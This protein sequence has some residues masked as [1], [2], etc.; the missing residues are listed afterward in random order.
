MSEIR[1][2]PA[3]APTDRIASSPSPN[4]LPLGS[5][6]GI[7]GGGQLGR[8]LA[9]AAA[10]LGYTCHVYT[11]DAACPAAHVTPHVTQGAWDDE[12]ALKHF[13]QNIDVATLEFENIPATVCRI[14]DPYVPLFPDQ[15]TLQIAQDRRAEKSFFETFTR[16]TPWRV[17]TSKTGLKA[18]LRTLGTPAI[19]KT[20]C[21]GYDGK[22]QVVIKAPEQAEAAWS[23]LSPHPVILEQWVPF[24]GE[25][26][27]LI[28]RRADGR[29]AAWEPG[30]NIHRNGVLDCT[31]LP[32]PCD[33]DILR[34]AQDI[35]HEAAQ[36]LNLIGL[37]SVEFFVLEDHSLLVNEMAPRPHNSGHWTLD[38]SVTD[39]F[40]QTIRAICGLPLGDTQ[41]RCS[42]TMKNLIGSD[43]TTWVNALTDPSACLHLYGKARQTPGRKMGHINYIKGDMCSQ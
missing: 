30:W 12:H 1:D 29:T 11:P 28:A 41:R 39:Q 23:H 3:P 21:L 15:H 33:P 22:G 14:L 20:C 9:L 6:I 25:V 31:R 40:E 32:A 26:S 7:L 38:A 5:R 18:A 2:R 34:Q 16:V 24:K 19:L 27:A 36:R 37:L 17:I 8:M 43:V 42:V 13:A 4:P 10:R 35:A